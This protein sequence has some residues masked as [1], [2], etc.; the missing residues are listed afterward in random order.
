MELVISVMG[1]LVFEMESIVWLII[2]LIK[3]SQ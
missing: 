2:F 1:L 3:L